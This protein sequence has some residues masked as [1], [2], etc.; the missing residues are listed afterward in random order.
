MQFCQIA[1]SCFLRHIY[2]LLH[3]ALWFDQG[4]SSV[5][6]LIHSPLCCKTTMQPYS[7]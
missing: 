6:K 7:R 3:A 4:F 2:S 5:K 1:A